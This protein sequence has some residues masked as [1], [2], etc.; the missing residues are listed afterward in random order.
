[1][2]RKIISS[3]AVQGRCL[4]VD[5]LLEIDRELPDVSPHGA[6][7]AVSVLAFKAGAP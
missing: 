5:D 2:G 7:S 1:V 6:I 3:V 4:T